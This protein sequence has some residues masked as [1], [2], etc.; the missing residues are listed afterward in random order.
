[1]KLYTKLFAIQ[2]KVSVTKDGINPHFRNKYMTLD[3][4]VETLQPFLNEN[5]L[6]VTHFIDN[7]TLTTRIVDIETAELL[8]SH[9][10]MNAT[11]PQKVGSEIT[12]WKRYNLVALFNICA[13]EDDDW[14]K[15]STSN[16]NHSQAS[17]PTEWINANSIANLIKKI[18]TGEFVADSGE[19]AVKLA[20]MYYKVSKE[21]AEA[22][23]TLFS[24]EI[25]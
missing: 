19:S 20:R 3:N 12:Y 13:D 4:I 14:N 10:P 21:N 5:K 15:A 8:D 22:I 1:M 7:G 18:K 2:G 17:E 9:F 24:K 23:K 6:L 25:L 11:D 16:D